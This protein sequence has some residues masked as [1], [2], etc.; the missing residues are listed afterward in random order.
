MNSSEGSLEVEESVANSESSASAVEPNQ[1]IF[2]LIYCLL[3][4]MLVAGAGIFL[5]T[6]AAVLG[7]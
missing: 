7:A 6:V 4:I 3:A 2:L 1:T 5:Y